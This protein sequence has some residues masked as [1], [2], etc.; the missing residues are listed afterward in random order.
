MDYDRIT[1]KYFPDYYCYPE[2]M[3]FA[4]SEA[5]FPSAEI[6]RLVEP[7]YEQQCKLLC[8]GSYPSWSEVLARFDELKELL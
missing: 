5:I 7:E 2:G 1:R 3:V 4:K 8:Y 6:S